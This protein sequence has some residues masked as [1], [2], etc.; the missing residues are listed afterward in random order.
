MKKGAS[1]LGAGI[2]S[3]VDGAVSAYRDQEYV[4][5]KEKAKS[6]ILNVLSKVD[7]KSQELLNLSFE[8]EKASS[9]LNDKYH[10]GERG[11]LD[12]ESLR[13]LIYRLNAYTESVKKDLEK[14]R[15]AEEITEQKND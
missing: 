1:A 14:G 5:N 13:G 8:L 2:K 7:Q 6:S 9:L 12:A 10:G 3:A 15:L 11:K 4:S